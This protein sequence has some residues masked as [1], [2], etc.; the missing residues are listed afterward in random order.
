MVSRHRPKGQW[1]AA[2]GQPAPRARSASQDYIKTV[3]GQGLFVVPPGERERSPGTR[4]PA[5]RDA[6]RMAM[7]TFGDGRELLLKVAEPTALFKGAGL[8]RL[9]FPVEIDSRHTIGAGVA[10]AIGGN[11]WLGQAGGDWLGP[12]FPDPMQ[13]SVVY[14]DPFA[15]TLVLPLTDEQLAVIEQ[16]RAGS[17]LRFSFDI[18][19]ALG[20]DPAV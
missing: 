10:F 12:W 15:T 19:I 11:A 5:L 18:Q 3:M 1:L 9:Q 8:H 6:D 20:Y 17:D 14:E 13:Q 16:R 4:Q 2:R 7:F